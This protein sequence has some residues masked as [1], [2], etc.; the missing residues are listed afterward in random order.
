MSGTFGPLIITD[1]VDAAVLAMLKLWL[2]TYLTQAEQE[3][4]LGQGWLMRPK[5][6]SYANVLDD[7]TFPDYVLP[8]VLVT[9]DGTTGDTERTAGAGLHAAW[10]NFVVTA[11]VR[12]PDEAGTK[13]VA[14]LYAGSI[15]R[16]LLQKQSLGGFAGGMRWISELVTPVA[17]TSDRGRNLAAGIG[18]FHVLVNEVVQDEAGP[19]QPDPE[20]DPHDYGDWPEVESVVVDVVTIPIETEGG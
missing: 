12:G 18:T 5:D 9:T 17:D 19:T 4:T 11:I 2:P 13:K 20:P 3:R 6:S 14:S 1:D 15:R 7:D 10:W 16:L 8:A